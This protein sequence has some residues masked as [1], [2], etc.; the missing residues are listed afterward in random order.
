M[1]QRAED[2]R[3]AL[4]ESYQ[5]VPS[6]QCAEV[7]HGTLY[8]LPRPAPRHAYAASV[9]GGELSGPFQR[10]R[11]GPGGWWI[12][13]EPELHLVPLEPVV[14]DIVGWRVERMPALPE[15]AYFTLV[16]DW[17]CEVISKSTE[18]I[19]RNEK[20]PL[21]AA[22][23]VSHVWLVDPLAKTLEAHTLGENGRWSEVRIH[24]GNARVR[25]APFED[26]ELELDAL[27]EP[28]VVG[29]GAPR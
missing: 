1:A 6:H 18:A 22:Q 15:T 17:I 10:G 29:G 24:Q 8:V 14:P 25:L 11:G 3:R 26:L 23:G 28:P 7:I 4:Y 13:D 16:P 2:S 9:L 5:R 21:Y 20:L 12:L 19:D 27:W